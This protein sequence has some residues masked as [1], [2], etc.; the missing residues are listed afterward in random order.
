MAWLESVTLEG[1]HAT[2]EPLQH[3]H[4]DDLV[5]AVKDGGLWDLC[6]TAVPEPG[7]MKGEIDRRLGLQAAGTMLPSGI[8]MRSRHS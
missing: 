1:P 2:L 6:Y 8:R 5:D 7:K 3:A 4:H